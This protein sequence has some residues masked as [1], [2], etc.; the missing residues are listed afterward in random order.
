MSE[1]DRKMIKVLILVEGQTEEAFVK[2]LLASHLRGLGVIAIPVIVAT[3]RLLTGDKKRGGYVPYPRLRAEVLRLLNDSSAPCVTTMLDYYGLAPEFPGRETPVG[4]TS[5]EKVSSVEQA[6]I[7][8]INSARF[9]PY[10]A[11]HEFEA[12]LFTEPTVIAS[13]FGQ[14]GLQSAL[15]NIRA[16]FPSPEDINDHEETAPSKR[17]GKLFPG[18]NKPFYGELIAE[19]IGIERIR[20]ECVHFAAWL[21]KLESFGSAPIIA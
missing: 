17:L 20:A 5:L 12:M 10:L 18:Y 15:Q 21:E 11:L 9:I 13:S 7:T 6:W 3:K 14:S 19:R 1:A 8:D 16:S 4:K 2:S